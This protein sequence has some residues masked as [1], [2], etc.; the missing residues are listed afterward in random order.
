MVVSVALDILADLRR[1]VAQNPDHRVVFLGRDG[2]SLAIAVEAVDPQFFAEHCAQVTISRKLAALAVL[3]AEQTMGVRLSLPDDFRYRIEDASAADGAFAALTQYLERQ[4]IALRPGS[5][6]T[7]VDSSFKGTV[8]EVLS[9]LYPQTSFRGDYIWHGPAATDPH[10]GTKRGFLEHCANPGDTGS[11][12]EMAAYEYTL[13]G[14]L[15]SPDGFDAQ[16]R[17]R[18]V[19]GRDEHQPLGIIDPEAIDFRYR[20]LTVRDAIMWAN[21]AAI[22]DYARHVGA[23][24]DPRAELRDGVR[25]YQEQIRSWHFDDQPEAPE[26]LVR[27]LDSFVRA[28]PGGTHRRR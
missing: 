25:T 3:D 23:A 24:T 16:G 7:I 20:D 13:R 1:Q 12:W 6:A 4:G 18:Q 28:G 9:A 8:Q 5:S 19:P 10:P 21:Q 22:R 27:F 26:S 2:T 17:P 11:V 14:P 15:S